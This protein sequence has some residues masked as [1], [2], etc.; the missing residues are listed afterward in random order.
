MDIRMHRI[1]GNS[2]HMARILAERIY[3]KLQILG[4]RQ[5]R[6]YQ[7]MLLTYPYPV[8]RGYGT[9]GLLVGIYTINSRLEWIREDVLSAMSDSL[10]SNQGAKA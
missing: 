6:F 10:T 9:R 8:K 5:V 3:M 7:G 1:P 2:E 4:T